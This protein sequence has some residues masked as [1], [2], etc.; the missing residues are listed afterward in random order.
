MK[1]K[2]G[3]IYFVGAGPGDPE[4]ITLKGLKALQSAQVIVYDRLSHPSLLLEANR[5][6]TFIY[7]GKQPCQHTLRQHDIQKELVIQAKKGKT[8]VRLKGGDPAVFGRVGEEAEAVSKHHIPYEIVP[9]ITAGSAAAIY[10]GVPLTHRE[11]SRSFAIVTGHSKSRDGKPEIEWEKLAKGVD[12]IVFY[13]GVK[14]LSYIANELV[15]HGKPEQ[16]ST[17]VTEWGTYGRQRSITAP[18]NK[19]AAKVK[20]RGMQNPAVIVVGDVTKLHDSL[21][22]VEQKPLTGY[23]IIGMSDDVDMKAHM[24]ALKEEGA[25]VYVLGTTDL[26][27]SGREAVWRL[28]E[29]GHT[30]HVLLHGHTSAQIV[31][32]WIKEFQIEI[33]RVPSFICAGKEAEA[34]MHGHGYVPSIVLPPFADT[35]MFMESLLDEPIRN[36]V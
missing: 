32:N 25:D 8:V 26:S 11:H 7:C 30:A 20:E 23:G 29:E 34:V 15:K 5:K 6:A 24:H 35:S 9:G 16:T 36:I 31:M 27:H 1:A 2:A 14:N 18:L 4:L 21:Q 3:K 10:T 13:M 19:I 17:L 12:T 33:D 28:L 22:W